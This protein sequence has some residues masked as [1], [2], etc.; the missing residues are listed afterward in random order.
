MKIFIKIALVLI[1]GSLLAEEPNYSKVEK[2]EGIALEQNDSNENTFTK[3]IIVNDFDIMKNEVSQ[4]YFYNEVKYNPSYFSRKEFCP[5]SFKIINKVGLCPDH[6]VE[7]LSILDVKKFLKHLNKSKDYHY[8]LPKL[9]EYYYLISKGVENN[10]EGYRKL[11]KSIWSFFN[12]YQNGHEG[13]VQTS[14]SKSSMSFNKNQNYLIGNVWEFTGDY[15]DYSKNIFKKDPS[16][17][18]EQSKGQNIAFFGLSFGME[19]SKEEF[20]DN[21]KVLRQSD[22]HAWA[23]NMLG[24]RLVRIKKR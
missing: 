17:S 9:S 19:L 15:L 12:S 24:F 6:P 21:Q 5:K 3:V 13:K 8:R 22:R 2:G 11:L 4:E 23:S 16:T 20:F 18:I 7:S 10:R 1:S 14:S